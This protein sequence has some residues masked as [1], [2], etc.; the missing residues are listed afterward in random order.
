[1]VSMYSVLD[2]DTKRATFSAITILALIIFVVLMFK[3]V[4]WVIFAGCC[5]GIL[6]LGYDLFLKERLFKKNVKASSKSS[7]GTK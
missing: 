7:K 5:A 4:G 6:Y 1:M 2:V 3:I